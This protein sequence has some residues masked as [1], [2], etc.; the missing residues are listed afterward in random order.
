MPVIKKSSYK[1]PFPFQNGH[2]CTMFPAIFRKPKLIKDYRRERI[3]TS[4][5]DFLD[6]DWM[7]HKKERAVILSH[8]LEGHTDRQ[9]M[10]GMANHFYEAGYDVLAWSYRGCSGEMNRK[11]QMYH[12]GA[13]YDLEEVVKH[14]EAQGIKEIYL[15]GFSLGGNLT[16]KYLGEYHRASIK[17]AV[18]FSVP[19]DLYTGSL[20]IRKR[21]N[22][23]Y[24]KR[25]L[26]SLKKKV[27]MKTE[28]FPD[29]ISLEPFKK[30]KNLMDFDDAYTAPIHGFENAVDY[31]EKSSSRNFLQ[32]IQVNT[33]VINAL[34]D[35]FLSDE[36]L[37]HSLFEP[38][39]LV[40]FETPTHGGHVGFVTR[41]NEGKYWS[42]Q[43]ALDFCE[44]K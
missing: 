17:A 10:I 35:P 42:E 40:H 43:R 19:L 24:S 21:Q 27:I 29:Q 41:N 30:I 1:A 6:L 33:L 28:Q 16:L 13:T 23:I 25:F 36:C 8:G 5:N 32:H 37:D 39:N 44:N 18:T 3:E 31:Y 11:L 26:K 7:D 4:D 15:V 2:L 34:N 14:V 9:Y 20:K 38:L 22:W 12:S